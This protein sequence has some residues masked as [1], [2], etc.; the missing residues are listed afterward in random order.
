MEKITFSGHESFQCKSLWLKKGYD[1][2]LNGNSFSNDEAV[3][4]LGVGKNMVAS[5][6]FWLKAFG[7]SENGDIPTEFGHKLF[8]STGFDPYIEDLSTIWLLHYQLVR[9]GIATLYQLLF[10]EFHKTR[11]EFTKSQLLTFLNR[12]FSEKKIHGFIFNENTISKDIDTLLKN[13][14]TPYSTTNF[15]DFSTLLLPL[16]LIRKIDKTTF[17]FNETSRS[18]LPPLVFLYA[19]KDLAPDEIVLPF[20]LILDASR[21]FCLNTNDLYDIFEKLNHWNSA[22]FFDNTA[23][24]QLFTMNDGLNKNEILQQIYTDNSQQ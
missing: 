11:N 6:R 19:L 9:N 14:V 7:I 24:E 17:C 16:N 5:I 13:Y 1:F 20:D 21:I 15:E 2:I 4:T 18:D 12:K 23:G 22:I 10:S 3:V 8:N